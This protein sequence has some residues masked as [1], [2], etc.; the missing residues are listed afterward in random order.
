VVHE[1]EGTDPPAVSSVAEL[2]GVNAKKG[3]LPREHYL[4]TERSSIFCMKSKGVILPGEV[5]RTLFNFSSRGAGGVVC[6]V[7]ALSTVPRA[8]IAIDPEGEHRSLSCHIISSHIISSYHITHSPLQPQS[9]LSHPILSTHI[10]NLHTHLSLLTSSRCPVLNAESGPSNANSKHSMAGSLHPKLLS[11]LNAAANMFRPRLQEPE[12]DTLTP[13]MVSVRAHSEEVFNR[14]IISDDIQKRILC[15]AENDREALEKRKLRDA[16]DT[17]I[18]DERKVKLFEATNT[19]LFKS[20]GGKYGYGMSVTVSTDRINSFESVCDR[21]VECSAQ[22]VSKV[23]EIR[24]M[25]EAIFGIS[26]DFDTLESS[27]KFAET[28]RDKKILQKMTRTI[29]PERRIVSTVQC[30]ISVCTGN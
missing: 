29:F 4:S 24:A 2:I 1:S 12:Y 19:E 5:V 20:L 18:I 23:E 14:K 25:N 16:V 21:L 27:I 8:N 10:L 17:E 26:T 15:T 11:A 13:I 9:T 22:A 7:W 28:N 3:I 30:N 6:G